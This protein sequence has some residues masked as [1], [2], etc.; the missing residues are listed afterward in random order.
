MEKHKGQIVKKIIKREGYSFLKIS[1]K[2]CISRNTLYNKFQDPNLNH[3][4]ILAIGEIIKY[5]FTI[6]F[7]EMRTPNIFGPDLGEYKKEFASYGINKIIELLMLEKK[8][9]GLLEHYN[10]LLFLLVKVVDKSDLHLLK[11]EAQRLKEEL[12]E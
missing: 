2:L 7:P 6:D 8:Y 11:K 5:D 12:E 1:E 9:T 4:L 10:Q 3:S